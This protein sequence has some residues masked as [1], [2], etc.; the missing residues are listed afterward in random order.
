MISHLA[1][2]VLCLTQ[3]PAYTHWITTQGPLPVQGF[4]L[5]LS[6]CLRAGAVAPHVCRAETSVPERRLISNCSVTRQG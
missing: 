2:F 5:Q 1:V 6:L 4:R 3:T